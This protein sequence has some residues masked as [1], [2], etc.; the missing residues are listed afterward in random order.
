MLFILINI[1]FLLTSTS[2]SLVFLII[3]FAI[4]GLSAESLTLLYLLLSSCILF[5]KLYH[6]L[7]YPPSISLIF[8]TTRSLVGILLYTSCSKCARI[9]LVE[10]TIWQATYS[11]Y[12]SLNFQWPLKLIKTLKR[13]F[14]T[15]QFSILSFDPRIFA[16]SIEFANL[17][18][19][20]I[21]L[22]FSLTLASLSWFRYSFYLIQIQPIFELLNL[23]QEK[24]SDL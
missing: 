10:H 19:Q 4:T 21:L 17:T 22:I 18:Y 16:S 8:Y 15:E 5:S 3:L 24:K 11:S 2:I 1:Q 12:N 20:S 14:L 6:P 23:S 7:S 13:F 9:I